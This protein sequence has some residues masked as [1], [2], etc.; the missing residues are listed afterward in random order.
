ML[1]GRPANWCAFPNVAWS[2]DLINRRKSVK[3]ESKGTTA[4]LTMAFSQ[5][6]SCAT[7][8]IPSCFQLALSFSKLLQ[9][10]VFMDAGLQE[11]AFQ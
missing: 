7:L 4:T 1:Q 3:K 9:Q 10:Q 6:V 11:A 5:N 2:A 8:Q